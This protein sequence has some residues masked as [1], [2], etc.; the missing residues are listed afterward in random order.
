MLQW[1]SFISTINTKVKSVHHYFNRHDFNL[2]ENN[3][4]DADVI[5]VCRGK[6]G[7][8]RK[9]EALNLR[10]NPHIW[11]RAMGRD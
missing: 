3:Y 4:Y 6:E 8:E 9:G 2:N 5:S 7:V 11:S 10:P 1:L